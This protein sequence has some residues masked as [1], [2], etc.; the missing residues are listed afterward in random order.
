VFEPKIQANNSFLW[1]FGTCNVFVHLSIKSFYKVFESQTYLGKWIAGE[2]NG[3]GWRLD[4]RSNSR[5]KNFD[6]IQVNC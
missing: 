3:Q 2:E 5:K 6:K 1:L 4:E